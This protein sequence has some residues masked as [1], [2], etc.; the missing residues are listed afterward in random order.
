MLKRKGRK[1]KEISIKIDLICNLAVS[2]TFSIKSLLV[3]TIKQIETIFFL[4]LCFGVWWN[5]LQMNSLAWNR[6]GLYLDDQDKLQTQTSITDHSPRLPPFLLE[7]SRLQ[8]LFF[9]SF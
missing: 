5:C 4:F 6:I 7:L 2:M 3:V 9:S 8:S 1:A